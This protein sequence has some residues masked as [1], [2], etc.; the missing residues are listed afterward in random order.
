M[1]PV[2]LGI[3]G[4]GLATGQVVGPLTTGDRFE[5]V[6]CGDPDPLS[7]SR[8]TER[9][10]APAFES[11]EQLFDGAELD[12]VY[13]ATPTKLHEQLTEMAFSRGIHVLVEKPVATTMDAA[14]RMIAA[15]QSAGRVFMVNHK[16]SADRDV[17]GMWQLTK[18]GG[19][20]RVR[21]VHR[22]HYSDWFYRARGE[23]ERDPEVGG[24]VLRQGAHE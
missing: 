20:G 11:A 24:V 23:D 14:E 18:D 1:A 3:I 12:A 10:G 22:W 5:V 8:F 2:R 15:A 4:F 17:L 13:I 9:F 19:L 16:H 21:A 6:A 7:R